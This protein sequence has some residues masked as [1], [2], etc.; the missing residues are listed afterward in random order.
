MII[1]LPKP[2]NLNDVQYHTLA[3]INAKALNIEPPNT[4]IEYLKNRFSLSQTQVLA[5]AKELDW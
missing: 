1:S 3:L 4:S 2:E 5:S